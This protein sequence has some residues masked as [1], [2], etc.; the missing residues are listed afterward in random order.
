VTTDARANAGCVGSAADHAEDIALPHGVAR[1]APRPAGHGLEKP[2]LARL[3][4]RPLDVGLQPGLELLAP[5][6]N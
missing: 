6:E 4:Q 5:T 2:G 3:Q 1:Q